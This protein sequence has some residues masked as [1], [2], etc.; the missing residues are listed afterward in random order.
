MQWILGSLHL[1]FRDRWGNTVSHDLV[2]QWQ[3]KPVD[4]NNVKLLQHLFTVCLSIIQTFTFLFLYFLYFLFLYVLDHMVSALCS[5]CVASI[6]SWVPVE[7]KQEGFRKPLAEN[8]LLCECVLKQTRSCSATIQG[9][10]HFSG[11]L[12]VFMAWILHYKTY[13][14][15][16]TANYPNEGLPWCNHRVEI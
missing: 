7:K 16:R 11:A 12:T 1:L 5:S 15:Q 3:Y 14:T 10:E 13:N 8:V 2:E 9:V 4:F 6:T